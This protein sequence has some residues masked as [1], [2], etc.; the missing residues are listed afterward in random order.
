MVD[1][2]LEVGRK[3][4]S[5]SSECYAKLYQLYCIVGQWSGI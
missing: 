2:E 1:L 4:S 3:Y 5:R